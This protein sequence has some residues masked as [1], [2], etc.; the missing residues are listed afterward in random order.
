MGPR[1]TARVQISEGDYAGAWGYPIAGDKAFGIRPFPQ[2]GFAKSPDGPH[3]WFMLDQLP[4]SADL[5]ARGYQG[6]VYFRLCE[7]YEAEAMQLLA[8]AG[9]VRSMTDSAPPPSSS[10]ATVPMARGKLSQGLAAS[11]STIFVR[12]ASSRRSP[13]ST[14]ASSSA[15]LI[16]FVAMHDVDHAAGTHARN[17]M[18]R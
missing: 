16:I 2:I 6:Q 8:A 18:D 4:S 5:K 9:I 11:A 17:V 1:S 13:R 12:R 14:S 3:A 15:I 7:C 10:T